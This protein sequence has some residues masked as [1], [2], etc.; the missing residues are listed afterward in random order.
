[1][2]TTKPNGES[3]DSNKRSD[4]K[5]AR[6]IID[7]EQ[8]DFVVGSPPCTPFCCRNVH[9]NFKGMNKE[10]VDRMVKE[11]LNHLNFAAKVH[12]KHISRGRYSIHEHPATAISWDEKPIM[13]LIMRSDTMLVTADQCQYGLTAKSDSGEGLPALKPT[14]F[15]TNVPPL[16]KLLQRRC[17]R[18][19]IHQPL[20]SGRCAQAAFY[21]WDQ[22][23]VEG[24]TLEAREAELAAEPPR[25]FLED[26]CNH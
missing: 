11:G 12:R 1:M 24:R 14:K 23:C 22:G 9:M 19:H 7:K 10:D 5:L 20:V 26:R 21:P 25:G 18:S 16:A 13:D 15:L 17:Y 8:Q 4:R 3:W 2:R 6:E